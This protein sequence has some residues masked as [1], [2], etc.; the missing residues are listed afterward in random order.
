M[1]RRNTSGMARVP[2]L[3]Q[4]QSC[5]PISDFADDDPVR[6]EPQRNLEALELV[7]LRCRQHAQ[8]V[9]RVEQQLLGIFD[10]QHAIAGCQTA[11]LFEDGI[12]NSR[13]PRT[14]STDDEHIFPGADGFLNHFNVVQPLQPSNEVFLHCPTIPRIVFLGENPLRLQ[15][16]ETSLPIRLDPDGER[17]RRHNRFNQTRKPKFPD[18]K[19]R[20]QNR[21]QLGHSRFLHRGNRHHCPAS[22]PAGQLSYL[23]K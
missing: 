4:R 19:L 18:R 23:L 8:T 5:R 10:H 13:L 2:G 11:D 1:D 9:G 21:P 3:Q 20:F 22:L 7:K 14:R 15:I 17:R 6:L 12:R 16:A